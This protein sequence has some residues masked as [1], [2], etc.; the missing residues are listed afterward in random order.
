[1]LE[2]DNS[3]VEEKTLEVINFKQYIHN[4]EVGL[5]T[6]ILSRLDEEQVRDIVAQVQ[7]HIKYFKET[8]DLDVEDFLDSTTRLKKMYVEY[9]K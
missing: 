2:S 4:I 3:Y 8:Y 9:S 7:E 5:S 1:M 6:S